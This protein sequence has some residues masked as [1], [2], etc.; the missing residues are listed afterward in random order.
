M[1]KSSVDNVLRMFLSRYDVKWIAPLVSKEIGSYFG[2]PEAYDVFS[3]HGLR[4]KE[5]RDLCRFLSKGVM[6]GLSED[7]LQKVENFAH[8]SKEINEILNNQTYSQAFKEIE[9]KI[10]KGNLIL[11][12]PIVVRFNDGSMWLYSGRK[13]IYAA[14]KNGVPIQYFLVTQPKEKKEIPEEIS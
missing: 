14:K 3:K 2:N 1:K 10:E 7:T 12:A 9:H 4:F 8:S 11:E 5:D 6:T 13:R